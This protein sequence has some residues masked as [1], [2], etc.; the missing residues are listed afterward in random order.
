M[1]TVTLTARSLPARQRVTRRTV[2]LDLHV[3][4]RRAPRFRAIDSREIV[5]E[6]GVAPTVTGDRPADLAAMA[7]P[8]VWRSD[9]EG[10]VSTTN[11]TGRRS[12]PIPSASSVATKP[13]SRRSAL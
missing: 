7:R 9:H 2:E 4:S 5:R 13:P 1:R 10:M 6:A 12:T 11:A 3:P 8:V